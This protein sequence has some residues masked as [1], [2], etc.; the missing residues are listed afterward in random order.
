MSGGKA[1]RNLIRVLMILVLVASAAAQ[2]IDLGKFKGVAIPYTLKYKD[3][4]MEKGRYDLETVKNRNSP[5]YF[6]KFKKG[7]KVICLVEGE[8]LTVEARAGSRLTDKSI[9]DSPRLKMKKDTAEKILIITVETGR[10]SQFPFQLLQ[11][12]L[13]Y[14]D[15]E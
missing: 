2:F 15:E 5:T 6:L 9:P 10:R 3:I 11:F 7:G 13:E 4:V 1:G 8:Q 12:N 14:E